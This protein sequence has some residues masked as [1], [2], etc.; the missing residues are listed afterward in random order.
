MA[1]N[2]SNFDKLPKY[3]MVER[4]RQIMYF[5]PIMFKWEWEHH[6]NAYFAMYAKYNPRSNTFNPSR[7]LFWV[8]AGSAEEVKE[9]FFQKF[10]E[11]DCIKGKTWLGNN[12]LKLDLMNLTETDS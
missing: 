12:P 7:V 9:K 6:D 4:G 10:T 8:S 5:H 3:L 11:L 1:I 2:R